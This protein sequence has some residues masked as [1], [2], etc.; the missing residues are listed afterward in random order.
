MSY[1][2][3]PASPGRAETYAPEDPEPQ[4]HTGRTVLIVL[5]VIAILLGAGLAAYRLIHPTPDAGQTGDRTPTEAVQSYLNALAVGDATTALTYSATQP[6]DRTF[7]TDDFMAA[8]MAA[9]PLTDIDVPAGQSDKTPAVIQATYTL[10]GQTVN[11]SF[12]VQKHGR[13]WLLNGGFLV[14]DISSLTS[15]GV[16]LTLNGADVDFAGQ[17]DLFP[18]VY[19]FASSDT[20]VTLDA[21]TFTIAYPESNPT[22]DQMH[23]TLSDQGTALILKAAQAK[24]DWCVAQQDIAPSGC[25]FQVADNPDSPVDQTTVTWTLASGA[26]KISSLK[27][28]LEPDTGMGYT[29]A[30]ADLKI[31]LNFHAASVDGLHL[32]N[33]ESAITQMSADFSDPS[34]IVVT[35]H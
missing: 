19:T 2:P 17:L 28:T 5:L 20:M 31:S 15:K 23:F 26:T 27:P 35:F 8:V 11:A 34:Q 1:P 7:M 29:S 22:F 6:E 30:T 25:G 12:T 24:L 4:R 16:A 18:G 14:L 33:N 21:G 10:G 9:N 13:N 3:Y 32:Y